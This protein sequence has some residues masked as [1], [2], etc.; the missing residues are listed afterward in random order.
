MCWKRSS[1]FGPLVYNT[2][3]IL[4]V[5]TR[6]RFE[7]VAEYWGNELLICWLIIESVEIDEKSGSSN[8]KVRRVPIITGVA[9]VDWLSS[10]TR[11]WSKTIHFNNQML[12]GVSIGRISL[13]SWKVYLPVRYST[14]R[15]KR[16]SD[17]LLLVIIAE[18]QL[19]ELLLMMDDSE[20]RLFK[21]ILRRALVSLSNANMPIT[22]NTFWIKFAKLS[23]STSSFWLAI[24]VIALKRLAKKA[25]RFWGLKWEKAKVSAVFQIINGY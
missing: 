6:L 11:I 3:I 1:N 25:R 22:L 15:C 24:L 5:V 13:H 16:F 4:S 23:C 17:F 9:I 19:A 14:T 12:I 7:D 2:W 18:I 20:A 10:G 21:K 8:F